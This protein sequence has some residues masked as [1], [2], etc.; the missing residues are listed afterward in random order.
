[1]KNLIL[2]TCKKS[3]KCSLYLEFWIKIPGRGFFYKILLDILNK[4]LHI[5]CLLCR[6]NDY[7]SR[8]L[9]RLPHYYLMTIYYGNYEKCAR[10]K[11]KYPCTIEIM[12]SANGFTRRY[13]EKIHRRQNPSVLIPHR[14]RLFAITK[15]MIMKRCLYIS[16]RI[17][18]VSRRE[19]KK[20]YR[21]FTRG[22]ARL[23]RSYTLWNPW[24]RNVSISQEGSIN[25][26]RIDR[27]ILARSAKDTIG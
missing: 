16:A 12:T 13:C 7:S 22:V 5:P 27:L 25:V 21:H 8:T 14:W 23:L 9:D 15:L 6:F 20:A 19:R 24:R 10:A 4:A 26:N 3:F 1:M 17:P 2:E 11:K 18:F